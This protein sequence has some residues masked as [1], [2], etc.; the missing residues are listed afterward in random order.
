MEDALV[1]SVVLKREGI[2]DLE[3]YPFSIP[4]IGSSMSY[5]SIRT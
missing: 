3:A 1:R 5:G 2:D 4:A